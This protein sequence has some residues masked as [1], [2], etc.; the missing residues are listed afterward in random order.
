MNEARISM[1]KNSYPTYD[2]LLYK[3]GAY[4]KEY[5][6]FSQKFFF[7]EIRKGVERLTSKSHKE[8]YHEYATCIVEHEIY[9]RISYIKGKKFDKNNKIVCDGDIN[10]LNIEDSCNKVVFKW[11]PRCILTLLVP[12][13]EL[14]SYDQEILELNYNE[15]EIDEYLKEQQIEKY[16]EE[17]KAAELK[18]A[19]R[20]VARQR[21]IE[22][23]IIFDE[24][25]KRPHIPQDVVGIVYMRDGGRCC[26]CGSTKDLQLDHIIPFSKGG[27][28][29]PEN[30]RLLC[31]E[32]NL[33][34]GNRI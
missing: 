31:K 5:S 20:Q 14:I 15:D 11:R 28:S 7:K 17:I 12:V 32:C 27:S 30:L 19:L 21:L 6:S 29:E 22:E 9:Y 3:K 33:K 13:N 2:D 24:N 1:E 8:C 23:G 26:E 16:K 18:K 34:K 4:I 10:V 25:H